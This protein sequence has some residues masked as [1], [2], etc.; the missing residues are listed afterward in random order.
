MCI[1]L[2]SYILLGLWIKFLANNFYLCSLMGCVGRNKNEENWPNSSGGDRFTM[3]KV[4]SYQQ[5]YGKTICCCVNF[6]LILIVSIKTL[7]L[8]YLL[9]LLFFILDLYQSYRN[10]LYFYLKTFFLV[11]LGD[12]VNKRFL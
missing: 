11:L 1:K 5:T 4:L 2:C 10:L 6:L 12:D 8:F 3:K 7:Q 9:F